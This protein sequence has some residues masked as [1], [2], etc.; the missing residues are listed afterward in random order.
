MGHLPH[1]PPIFPIDRVLDMYLY[2]HSWHTVCWGREAW[3]RHGGAKASKCY[4]GHNKIM[5]IAPRRGHRQKHEKQ[6]ETS[7]SL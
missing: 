5:W 1:M 7:E 2:L 3:N 6:S 4:P